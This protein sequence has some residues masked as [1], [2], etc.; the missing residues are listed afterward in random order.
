MD[1][2]TDRMLNRLLLEVW[3]TPKPVCGFYK[4]EF[5]KD[6]K[7]ESRSRRGEKY[8]RL[9]RLKRR[10]RNIPTYQTFHNYS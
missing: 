1:K 5:Y 6:F 8:N 4:G 2:Y 3:P 7:D 10:L 9:I